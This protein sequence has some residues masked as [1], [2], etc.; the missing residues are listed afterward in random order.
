VVGDG[1]DLCL[2]PARVEAHPR[3]DLAACQIRSLQQREAVLPHSV[4]GEADQCLLEQ[5]HLVLEEVEL[6]SGDPAA[7][8]EVDQV[9]SLG[10]LEVVERGEVE[11]RGLAE[12]PDL[13]VVF[14][15]GAGRDVR[16][17]HVRDF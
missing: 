7:R 14:L 5:H 2:L 15:T 17:S 10:Q 3:R 4:E 12:T 8:L 13:R 1:V 6:R 16:V 9:V 11:L